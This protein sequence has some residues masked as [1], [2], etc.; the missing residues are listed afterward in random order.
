MRS[1]KDDVS[2]YDKISFEEE[3]SMEKNCSND[4]N[5]CDSEESDSEHS[6]CT[7]RNSEYEQHKKGINHHLYYDNF[8]HSTYSSDD[9]DDGWEVSNISNEDNT[10]LGWREIASS[11]E[12]DISSNNH[13]SVQEEDSKE[14]D[15]SSD[16]ERANIE[17]SKSESDHCMHDDAE[18]TIQDDFEMQIWKAT[19][20]NTELKSLILHL[21]N[22]TSHKGTCYM[23]VTF[24]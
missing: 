3:D 24:P 18:S 4:N 11:N 12:D 2:K 7:K 8:Q 21:K 19:G 23:M 10:H 1:N 14:K 5:N 13:A 9:N 20:E 16:N 17:V 6:I 22:V 15:S